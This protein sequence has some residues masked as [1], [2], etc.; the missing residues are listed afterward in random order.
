MSETDELANDPLDADDDSDSVGGSRS[1]VTK[2]LVLAALAIATIAAIT[3]VVA[4]NLDSGSAR[5]PTATLSYVVPAGTAAEVDL[6]RAKNDIFPEYLEVQVGDTIVIRNDDARSH[7]L[8]PFT[9]RAGETLTYEFQE[10]G[11]YR[12]A[13]TVHGPGH[14][15]I[16]RVLRAIPPTSA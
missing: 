14:E 10:V 16:I 2:G 13:C 11:T 1:A 7:V 5:R 9:V 8:G 12:G 6:G 4:L 3:I 15:A